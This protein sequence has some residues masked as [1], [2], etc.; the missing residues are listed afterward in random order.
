MLVMDAFVNTGML[1]VAV[2]PDMGIVSK[3][4]GLADWPQN[5]VV[6]TYDVVV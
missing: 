3:Q 1:S 4:M 2:G 5:G 6:R